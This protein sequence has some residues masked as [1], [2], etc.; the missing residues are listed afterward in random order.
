MGKVNEAIMECVVKQVSE[1]FKRPEEQ[2]RKT[3]G[4]AIQFALDSKDEYNRMAID[5]AIAN[6]D[7]ILTVSATAEFNRKLLLTIKKV[8]E[9]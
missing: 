5:K 6:G 8:L 7:K 9:L 4:V 3:L 2:I 1:H